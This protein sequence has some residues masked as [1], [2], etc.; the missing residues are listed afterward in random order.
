MKSSTAIPSLFLLYSSLASLASLA[1]FALGQEDEATA[2]YLAN[3][4]VMVTDGDTKIL[5]DPLY[6]ESYGQYLLV[7]E[8]MKA[9]LFAGEAPF[10]DVD[11]IFISHYHGD[12]FSPDEI[13]ALMKAQAQIRLY[14]PAQAVIGMR[15]EAGADDAVVFERVNAVSLQYQDAP[16]TL[17]MD[18]LL[19]EAVRIPHSGWPTGRVNVENIVWRVTL[20]ANTTVLHMGDADPNDVHFAN[21]AAYWN[22]NRPAMAFPP[23][24]FFASRGGREILDGR[25]GARHSV[26]IHVPFSVPSD[27]LRRPQELRGSDLFLQSGETRTIRTD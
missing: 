24:W 27:P 16:V 5:F 12:H 21:D 18:K 8:A 3:E 11:A 17:T 10:E 14:A 23:Y 22:R 26:G 7:P 19:I 6:P 9:A 20:N 15:A 2:F 13:L 4:G 25:V 1:G